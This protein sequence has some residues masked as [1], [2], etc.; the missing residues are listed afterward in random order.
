MS[1]TCHLPRAAAVLL[2]GSSLASVA[3]AADVTG[4][5]VLTTDYV[6]RGVTYS[7]GHAALQAAADVALDSGVYLGAWAS[8]VDISN[9]PGQQRDLQLNYYVGYSHDFQSAWSVGANVVS[10]TFPG[11]EGDFEY[12][13]LEYSIVANYDDRAW[14]EYSYSPDVFHSGSDTHNIDLYAEWGLPEQLLFGAGAG[15]YDVSGLSGNGYAY[16]QAGITRPFGRIDIDLRY[17]DTSRSVPIISTSE[18]AAARIAL[19][20]KFLF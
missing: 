1:S 7:D 17:H 8:S 13:F 6:F 5:A 15:Y 3:C 9:G 19:S 16:W 18:R 2:S 4:Y 12:D 14:L 20:A 11:T 10:Y